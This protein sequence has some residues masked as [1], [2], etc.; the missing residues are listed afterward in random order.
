M[1]EALRTETVAAGGHSQLCVQSLHLTTL[2]AHKG[3]TEPPP[4]PTSLH[5]TKPT[6]QPAI[7]SAQ[8]KPVATRA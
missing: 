8:P 7:Q 2:S 4:P 1:P 5:Y 6:H 3:Q